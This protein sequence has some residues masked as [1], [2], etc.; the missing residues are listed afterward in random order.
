[1]AAFGLGTLP[2][3]ITMGSGAALVSRAA[4]APLVRRVAGV[5]MLAFGMIQVFVVGRAWAY[6][7][8]RDAP[9][10]SMCHGHVERP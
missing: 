4:R 3:L 9:V 10:V 2:A 8:S 5:T 6:V 7:S 1:M